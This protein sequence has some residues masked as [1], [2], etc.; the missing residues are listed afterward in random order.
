MW[1]ERKT[2][3]DFVTRNT[4]FHFSYWKYLSSGRAI[5]RLPV[6]LVKLYIEPC[7]GGGQR[8]N[9]KLAAGGPARPLLWLA[10]LQLTEGGPGRLLQR[11]IGRRLLI[12]PHVHVHEKLE[13]ILGNAVFLH[14]DSGFEDFLLSRCGWISA[15]FCRIRICFRDLRIRIGF[16]DSG[17]GFSTVSNQRQFEFFKKRFR[18]TKWTCTMS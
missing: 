6:V 11:G 14:P 4:K 16:R 7:I 17:F 15:I 13:R 12:G 3:K 5:H 10:R 8:T 2:I 9:G 1:P 18:W